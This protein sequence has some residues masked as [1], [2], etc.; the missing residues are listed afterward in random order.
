M[1]KGL[2]F[3]LLLDYSGSMDQPLPKGEAK[4]GVLRTEIAALTSTVSG[5]A[6]SAALVFGANPRNACRDI[7]EFETSNKKLSAEIQKIKPG[8]YGKTPL[9]A[10]LRRG[11][12]LASKR[13]ISTMIAVTDGG[14]TC[15]ED[16]CEALKKIDRTLDG[17]NQKFRLELI[18]F[19]L[20]SERGKLMCFKDLR[21]K[22]IVVN[23]TEAGTGSDLQKQLKRSQ[24]EA[25]SESDPM[26]DAVLAQIKG[27]RRTRFTDKPG[28]KD[29]I[30]PDG[31]AADGTSKDDAILEVVGAPATAKFRAVP[32]EFEAPSRDWLGPYALRFRAGS[33]VI[34]YDDA[35]GAT[36][37]LG[38]P[39]GSYTRIPWARLLKI[40]ES[41]ARIKSPFLSL[42]WKAAAETQ[43]VHG[44]IAK[45]DTV[46]ELDRPDMIVPKIPFGEWDVE[47]TSPE[48][49]VGG[50]PPKR[51]SVSLD[52]SRSLDLE[53]L[54]ADE[55]RW[56]VNPH[57]AKP[58]VLKLIKKG[59]REER[60]LVSPGQKMLPIPK[61]ASAEWMD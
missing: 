5:D 53:R 45:F 44:E 3:L 49:L 58:T 41:Q 56:I 29:A 39:P 11:V 48:W 23:L 36:L 2:A 30:N 38:F 21:L 61:D 1:M 28:A 6:R 18:G 27:A 8:A 15:G 14:D 50:L 32:S 4:I 22:N 35:N 57:P 46:A 40:F 37:K 31:T 42:N 7:Q 19:D 26:S 52:G 51:V 54:Y 34:S 10:V 17:K 20:R 12:E 59:G 33:Y 60:Y 55:L 47:V 16:P 25:I 24:A 13:R 9:S 43:D